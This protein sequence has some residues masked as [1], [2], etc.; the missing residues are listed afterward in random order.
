MKEKLESSG[1]RGAQAANANLNASKRQQNLNPKIDLSD[2]EDDEVDGDEVLNARR[3]LLLTVGAVVF[4]CLHLNRSAFNTFEG[5][6]YICAV[7]IYN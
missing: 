1:V 3:L 5:V 2:S 7:V 4:L 6:R